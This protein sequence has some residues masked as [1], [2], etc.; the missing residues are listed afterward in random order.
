[1][2]AIARPLSRTVP[3]EWPLDAPP[4]FPDA[5]GRFGSKRKHD[6]HTGVDLYCPPDTLV[7]AVEDGWVVGIEPFTGR[8]VVDPVTGKESTWWND[9]SA[10]LVEGARGVVVYGEVDASG[11]FNAQPRPLW[12]GKRVRAG[13]VI[14]IVSEPVLKRFK[15]RPT[16]MLHLEL[17]ATG[18]RECAWWPLGKKRPHGLLDP[19]PF[20]EASAPWAPVFDLKT[21][22]GV[23]FRK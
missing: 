2:S 19:T 5:P 12:V 23:H 9:T 13:E 4:M 3:W 6:V 20:L 21:Y 10:V 8:G 14:A 18:S 17:M 16:M 15:G 11:G 1:M 7:R 22:D